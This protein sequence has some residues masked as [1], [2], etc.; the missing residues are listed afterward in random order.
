MAFLLSSVFNFQKCHNARATMSHAL[1][2]SMERFSERVA[3]AAMSFGS[4]VAVMLAVI[5]S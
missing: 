4:I 5:S 1:R 2:S 3:S